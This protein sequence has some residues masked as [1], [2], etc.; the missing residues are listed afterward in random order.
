MD[1]YSAGVDLYYSDP[2]LGRPAIYR[3]G[4]VGAGVPVTVI[5]SRADAEAGYGQSRV[6]AETG[7]FDVRASEVAAPAEGDTITFAGRTY[8]VTG[9]PVTD[10]ARLVWTLK[11]RPS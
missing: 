8:V 9:D 11:T 3:A 2:H 5:E 10:D 4:G 7:V 1:A 6:I